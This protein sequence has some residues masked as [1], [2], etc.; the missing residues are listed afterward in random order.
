MEIQI[1]Q[2]KVASANLT[3]EAF[4]ETMMID[5]DLKKAV[6]DNL[7][8]ETNDSGREED[9][10]KKLFFLYTNWGDIIEL[11]QTGVENIPV[12]KLALYQCEV[13][14]MVSYGPKEQIAGSNM[15]TFTENRLNMNEYMVV[16]SFIPMVEQHVETFIKNLSFLYGD[17]D[18]KKVFEL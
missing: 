8:I 2:P 15:L 17:E 4:R 14:D 1:K 16:H 12:M 10:V 18:F 3:M 9:E 5:F 6:I 13:K 11:Y 7:K